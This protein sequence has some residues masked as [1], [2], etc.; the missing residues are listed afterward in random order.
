[1]I[2]LV[3]QYKP[4]GDNMTDVVIQSIQA[5]L[6]NGQN[7]LFERIKLV[8]GR[9][10]KCWDE[11]GRGRNVLTSHEQLDQYLYSYGPMTVS[12]WEYFLAQVEIPGGTIKVIDYGC[13]QGLACVLLFDFKKP[14]AK[15]VNQ[16]VLIEPSTVA[17]AR[18]RAML[19]CYCKDAVIEAVNK[20][21]D[22]I[23]LHDLGLSVDFF[24]LHL[25]SNVLDI[26]GFDYVSLFSKILQ[27]KGKHCVLAVSHD[28]NFEGGSARFF[29]AEKFIL[30]LDGSGVN[31]QSSIIE[32]F[33]PPAGKPA[34]SWQ[35][36]L[37]V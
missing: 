26:D 37:E 17:L 20:E 21:L 13:G 15:R 1:M 22:Q 19:E 25:F 8:A 34:I 33:T 35:I 3:F 29:E 5:G 7:I 10:A 6:I 18:A 23:L 9:D 31:I 2:L 27:T 28:R 30:G 4:I 36:N 24:T 11:L 32:K 12:Q 16:V 14:L